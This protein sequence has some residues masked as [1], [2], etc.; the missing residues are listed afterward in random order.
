MVEGSKHPVPP[1][2]SGHPEPSRPHG[3]GLGRPLPHELGHRPPE[4]HDSRGPRPPEPGEAKREIELRPIAEDL[5]TALESEDRE[6]KIKA[7]VGLLSLFELKRTEAI[8]EPW[9]RVGLLSYLVRK[10]EEPRP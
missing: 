10:K 4:P 3:P 8:G 2:H 1:V 7:V 5:I 9:E 6:L